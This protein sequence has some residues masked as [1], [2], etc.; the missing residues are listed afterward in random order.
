MSSS[1]L[2]YAVTF[3]AV[4]F[5]ARWLLDPLLG[6]RLPFTTFF[7][8]V[9]IAARIGGLRPA[10]LATGLGFLLALYFFPQPRYSF[11]GIP[12]PHL[13]GLAMFFTVCLATALPVSARL[14]ESPGAGRP[15]RRSA[16]K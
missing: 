4:A 12:G 16:C 3:V 5:A 15:N 1:L 2:A 7:V 8:A 9:V 11:D 6:E 10:L 14:C 13:M